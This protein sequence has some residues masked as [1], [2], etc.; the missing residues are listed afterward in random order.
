M[1]PTPSLVATSSEECLESFDRLMSLL[2]GP[3]EEILGIRLFDVTDARGR[4]M[5]WLG[6]LGARQS[7][8]VKSSLDYRL[9]DAPKVKEQILELLEDLM[10]A[11]QDG[12]CI[13]HMVESQSMT[14]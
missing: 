14:V 10:E 4:F 7:V 3:E 9:R 8:T 2:S 5:I 11:L 1:V 13:P 12:W 6:N